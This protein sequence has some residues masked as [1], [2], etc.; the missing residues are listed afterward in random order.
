MHRAIEL[1]GQQIQNLPLPVEPRHTLKSRRHHAHTK[2]CL[3]MG[4]RLVMACVQMRLVDNLKCIWRIGGGEFF[5]Y[6]LIYHYGAFLMR[7]SF[8]FASF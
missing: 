4:C 8:E 2:M 7:H 5:F 1:I 3:A 6:S